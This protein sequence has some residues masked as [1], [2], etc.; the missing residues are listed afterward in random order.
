MKKLVL[1]VCLAFLMA[2]VSP[3]LAGP[4]LVMLDG[5]GGVGVN[6]TAWITSSSAN[7]SFL[8][9]WI[10]KPTA[11]MWYGNFSEISTA[12]SAFGLNFGVKDRL[13]LSYGRQTA[14]VEHGPNINVDSFGA[15]LL[16]IKENSFDSSFVPALSVGVT[17]RKN[18]E[19]KSNNDLDDDG[20]EYYIVAS[21]IVTQ[22]PIPLIFSG[23]V[24]YTDALQRGVFGFNDD[25]HDFV[26]NFDFAGIV[27][28]FRQWDYLKTV[29]PGF[30]YRS[31]VKF[32]TP[33]KDLINPFGLDGD[34]DYEDAD[35]WDVFADFMVTDNLIIAFGYLWNGNEG[36]HSK[37]SL[38]DCPFFM[39]DYDF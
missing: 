36:S 9:G 24:T 6:P 20:F 7:T 19:F 33:N 8:D 34:D 28:L 39:L 22:T 32:N 27:P 25:D 29:V 26:W 2:S 38:G 5:A 13:E 14:C 10:Q 16:L 23:G 12:F 3:V 1:T 4:P 21:K 18:H 11:A 30:E 31:G 37:N 15:K 35:Y 17:Y